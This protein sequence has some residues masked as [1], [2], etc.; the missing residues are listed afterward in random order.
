M[1]YNLFIYDADGTCVYGDHQNEHTTLVAI[2]EADMVVRFNFTELQVMPALKGLMDNGDV[3]F[4]GCHYY[5]IPDSDLYSIEEQ[6]RTA[7]TLKVMGGYPIAVACRLAREML[8]AFVFAKLDQTHGE[9]KA[10]LLCGDYSAVQ[11][12]G[13]LYS[14]LTQNR[15]QDAE[16]LDVAQ[17]P[18]H[19]FVS[20]TSGTG[21]RM[22]QIA[23][24]S[25][26]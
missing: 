2:A 5:L 6:D 14:S 15:E 10:A 8:A 9:T 24:I 17:K 23:V 18:K 16:W 21:D 22:Y 7:D 3:L 20:I 25:A 13:N 26:K 4:M 12:L 11:R 1:R 19:R